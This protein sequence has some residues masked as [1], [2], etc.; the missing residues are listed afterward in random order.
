MF[1][2]SLEK[3][4]ELLD[5]LSKNECHHRQELWKVSVTNDASFLKGIPGSVK[6]LKKTWRENH[7]LQ[8]HLFIY[9]L[10]IDFFYSYNQVTQKVTVWKSKT[11]LRTAEQKSFPFLEILS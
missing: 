5:K 7:E 3:Q 8:P 10:N 4:S 2:N 11:G 9:L 6:I 1:K